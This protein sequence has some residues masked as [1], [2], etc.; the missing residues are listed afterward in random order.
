MTSSRQVPV[1]TLLTDFGTRDTFVAEMKGVLLSRCP[2]ARI[3]DITHEVPPFDAS[4]GAFLLGQAYP[5]FPPGTIHIGVVDPGVGSARPAL[6]L[7][8]D[9]HFFLGPDNGLFTFPSRRD[10]LRRIWRLTLPARR[11]AATFHGRD[12]FAPAAAALANGIAPGRLGSPVRSLVEIG[13]LEAVRLSGN[14]WQGRV[15]WIDRFGNAMTNLSGELLSGLKRPVLTWGNRRLTF[16][17]RT[18][19]DPRPRQPGFLINSTGWVEIFWP[20]GSAKG[21]LGVRRGTPVTLKGSR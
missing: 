14:A 2:R 12:L 17:A 13:T 16:L 9:R 15:M 10:P 6:L 1:I 8:A 20:L 21:H 18:Y 3:V 19:S 11:V 5:S 4:A 7:R